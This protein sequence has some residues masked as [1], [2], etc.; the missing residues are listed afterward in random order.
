MNR[1]QSLRPGGYEH[2]LFFCDGGSPRFYGYTES[3]GWLT[4]TDL[5]S[6]FTFKIY[7]YT[8]DQIARR[9]LN[10][11]R[12]PATPWSSVAQRYVLW[13][14]IIIIYT[15]AMN[16]VHKFSFRLNLVSF[17]IRISLGCVVSEFLDEAADYRYDTQG[18]NNNNMG[19]IPHRRKNA[20]IGYGATWYCKKAR[21]CCY[22][23][24]VQ[25]SYIL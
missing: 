13:A 12:F 9:A 20:S 10:K 25:F 4:S 16:S 19:R 23:A 18:R 5:G 1:L 8:W 24:P 15:V 7:D 3:P 6:R 14:H 17:F 11:A 22:S 2:N 21:R